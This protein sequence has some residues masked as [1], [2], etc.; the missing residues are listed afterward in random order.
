MSRSFTNQHISCIWIWPWSH[1]QRNRS[2]QRFGKAPGLVEFTNGRCFLHWIIALRVLASDR[3]LYSLS[4]IRLCPSGR[5]ERQRYGSKINITESFLYPLCDDTDPNYFINDIQLRKLEK[6]APAVAK[7]VQL[8]SEESIPADF[9][10]VRTAGYSTSYGTNN[11]DSGV[12]LQVDIPVQPPEV[13]GEQLQGIGSEIFGTYHVCAGYDRG[14][15]DFC[16]GDTGGPLFLFDES[17]NLVQ[18][19][20]T[21][22]GNDCARPN[23]PVIDTRVSGY[24]P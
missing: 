13:C 23:S 9:E 1:R 10:F 20:I 18:V 2:N 12:L 22:F 7:F 24:I 8:N 3:S 17:E 11:P 21:S 15:C 5:K 14:G 16:F 19:G 4:W 6:A